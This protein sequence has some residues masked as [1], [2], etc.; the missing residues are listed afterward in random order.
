MVLNSYDLKQKLKNYI[1]KN[2]FLVLIVKI[3][4]SFYMKYTKRFMINKKESNRK[5]E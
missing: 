3:H 2:T 4:F 5:H 1:S